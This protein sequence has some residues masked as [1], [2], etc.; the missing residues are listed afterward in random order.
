MR[1]FHGSSLAGAFL[2]ADGLLFLYLGGWF[3]YILSVCIDACFTSSIGCVFLLCIFKTAPS[4]K[5]NFEFPEQNNRALFLHLLGFLSVRLCFGVFFWSVFCCLLPQESR[6]S[7][8]VVRLVYISTSCEGWDVVCVLFSNN[9]NFLLRMAL[10]YLQ[11][12]R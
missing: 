7:V 11:L 6:A 12:S 8:A 3:L 2:R 9:F 10:W 5:G 1:P 4:R